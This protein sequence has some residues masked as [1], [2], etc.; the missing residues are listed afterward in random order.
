M[1]AWV[2]EPELDRVLVRLRRLA[3]GDIDR[4]ASGT[5]GRDELRN[6]VSRSAGI[7]ISDRPLST[8][9]PKQHA[10]AGAGDDEHVLALG[11]GQLESREAIEQIAQAARANHARLFQHVFVDLVVAARAPVCELAA[12]APCWYGPPST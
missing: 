7:A 1:D 5:E 6:A 4:V 8:Q 3:A 12:R 2:F 9:H 11:R 10:A